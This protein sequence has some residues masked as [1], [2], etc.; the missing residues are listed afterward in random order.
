MEET[1]TEKRDGTRK[2]LIIVFLVIALALKLIREI[3]TG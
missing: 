2:T 3:F 1:A